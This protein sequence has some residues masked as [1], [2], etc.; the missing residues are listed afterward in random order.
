MVYI[1][2][3]ENEFV[4][5]IYDFLLQKELQCKLFI[6]TNNNI[7]NRALSPAAINETYFVVHLEYGMNLISG[8]SIF[9]NVVTSLIEVLN[10]SI[11]NI[12]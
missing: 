1:R 7:V 3:K 11:M 10:Q 12:L 9:T 4:A 2:S 5:F 6:Q 8:V